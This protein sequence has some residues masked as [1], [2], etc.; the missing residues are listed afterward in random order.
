MV[1]VGVVGGVAVTAFVVVRRR[2]AGDAPGAALPG[3]GPDWAPLQLVPPL[4]PAPD[5]QPA[6]A[7]LVES[8]V[9]PADDGS[10]PASHPVKAKLSSGIFHEP[11]SRFYSVTRAQRCYLDAEAATADGLRP[12]KG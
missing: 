12:P 9:A 6:V 5:L 1:V 8:F 3:R 10:C 7:P 11:G 4:P 2:R